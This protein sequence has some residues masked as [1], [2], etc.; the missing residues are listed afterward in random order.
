[1]KK[2]SF[3]FTSPGSNR[4]NASRQHR[5]GAPYAEGLE[6]SEVLNL[7]ARIAHPLRLDDLLRYLDLSR[8]AKDSLLNLLSK[9]EDEGRLLRLSG[10]R[11]TDAGKAPLLSGVLS[12]QR[13]GAGF[14]TPD[15][16]PGD[17]SAH[18]GQRDIFIHP[19]A[20]GDAWHGDRVE[21]LSQLPNRAGRGPR[22]VS[23]RP[24]SPEGRIV[25][26]LERGQ[27]ELAVH[28]LRQD[29][30]MREEGV[31]LCRPAD[32][33]FAFLV[34]ADISA[35][36]EPPKTGEL[37]LVV[38]GERNEGTTR[39]GES[40]WQGV[41][42]LSLGRED[43]VAVQE[44]L[45]KINH[46][47]PLDFPANVLAEAAGLGTSLDGLPEVPA[48]GPAGAGE[49]AASRIPFRS[50]PKR[51]DLRGLPFVTIDG[52]DAR[53]FDDAVHVV[54]LPSGWELWV[55]IAD[56]GWFVHPGSALDKEARDRG[57]SCYFP[58]SVEPM[59]PE[60]LSNGLCSLRPDEDRLVMA[61]RI[62]FDSRG[63][64]RE[65]AFFP[66][67]IRSRARLTYEEV[68]AAFDLEEER[69]TDQHK[70]GSDLLA[71]LPGLLEAKELALLLKKQREA[72]G[73]LDF[74]IPEARFIVDPAS[75]R[76]LEVRR[77]ERLF[78]HRLI[79]ECMLAANEAVA[80]YLTEQGTPFP[81]RVHPAPD[82]ERLETLFRTLAATGLAPR[83]ATPAQEDTNAETAKRLCRVLAESRGAPHEYLVNRLML[84]AMMQ[85]RYSPD[86]DGHFGLASPCY[87]H[88]TSPIRRYADL[89]T[90]RA[91]RIALGGENAG[92]S[93]PSG[94]KLLAVCDQCNGRER[95]ATEAEREIA[96]R[97]GCLVLREHVGETFAGIIS[98][99]SDF[100]FFVELAAMPVE[101]MV[102]LDSL[103]DLFEYDA[104]RQELLG[105]VSGLRFRLGDAV[106]VR[107]ADVNVGR[108]EINL[109]LPL[110]AEGRHRGKNPQRRGTEHRQTGRPD[111][112]ER[113][114]RQPR[115]PERAGHRQTER[116]KS[117]GAKSGRGRSARQR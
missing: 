74:D 41:A 110:V 48:E 16:K 50:T 38:P 101:G 32:P 40:V 43:D 45:V 111:S 104:D 107:V 95:T 103:D 73:S 79:E 23:G 112:Q 53:D 86:N 20:M 58:A 42:R 75:G 109:D 68:Q 44:R 113:S 93:I 5:T 25:R 97:L 72:R 116:R 39:N 52:E 60:A 37:L 82:P 1:M 13:S 26:V 59:L 61:A 12:V 80:R 6:R 34:L 57:N 24:A 11:W 100:G 62:A 18:T 19:S 77:R 92:H 21:I 51:Q 84:R 70:P 94:Q 71:R 30:A 22:G 65:A 88:F 15:K 87:C 98:G 85:A 102:R 4:K 115:S 2:K 29:R 35:L 56:V 49:D 106:T 89:L 66:G 46:L 64:Y 33:R 91:L 114:P 63:N 99:V 69:K 55:A 78:A 7:F 90:H 76:V 27:K 14:V 105:L 17:A 108:L 67:L 117:S 47:I 54:R 81:Y 9:L 10:G 8:R 28:V 96:R 31:A 3:S 36:P 83:L